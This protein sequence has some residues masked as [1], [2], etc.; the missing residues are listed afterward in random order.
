MS[1]LPVNVVRR[2]H[3]MIPLKV[4]RAIR[5]A[6]IWIKDLTDDWIS[7]KEQILN[8]MDNNTRKLFTKRDEHT[9]NIVALNEMELEILVLW[10]KLTGVELKLR[11]FKERRDLRWWKPPEFNDDE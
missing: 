6:V 7:C 4:E 1:A 11:S 2:E 10:K 5:L 9:K 3:E 8:E